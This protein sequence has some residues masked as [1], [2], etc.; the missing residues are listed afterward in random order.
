MNINIVLFIL[1]FMASNLAQLDQIK[2]GIQLYR[3]IKNHYVYYRPRITGQ[4]QFWFARPTEP[5]QLLHADFDLVSDLSIR[6]VDE[7]Y[8]HNS[9]ILGWFPIIPMIVLRMNLH[10]IKRIIKED[11]YLLKDI[12]LDELQ[13]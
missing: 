3:Y 1:L 8:L 7:K 4:I 12:D 9:L 2:M 6:F 10:Q 5:D 11:K 13:R